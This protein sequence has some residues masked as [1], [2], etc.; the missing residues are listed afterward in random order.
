MANTCYNYMTIDSQTYGNISDKIVNTE[1]NIDF[2]ILL[3]IPKNVTEI[4]NPSTMEPYKG[5]RDWT[6][7]NVGCPG[8]AVE[9]YNEY[10][11]DGSMFI[12]FESEW[13]P[14]DKWFDE[15][16]KLVKRTEEV[17]VTL[18]LEYVEYDMEFAG[19]LNYICEP[20][21]VGEHYERTRYTGE[22][23]AEELNIDV[24]ELGL[25]KHL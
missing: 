6:W 23:L 10:L 22:R 16:C 1:G 8:P 21:N 13:S 17:P 11:S 14:P 4:V 15:V 3:P 7:E 18:E 25:G 24:T 9:Q 20:N 2:N 12:V 19:K 5:E